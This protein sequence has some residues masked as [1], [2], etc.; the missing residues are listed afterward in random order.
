MLYDA[1]HGRCLPAGAL[2]DSPLQQRLGTL[3]RWVMLD[4]A[5]ATTAAL[6]GV[7]FEGSAACL[8]EV[9]AALLAV[10]LHKLDL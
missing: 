8:Q 6:G 2:C 1:W 5:L 10:K 7:C 9:E 4:G 3:M